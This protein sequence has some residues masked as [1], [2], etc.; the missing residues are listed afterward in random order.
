MFEAAN[1]GVLVLASLEFSGGVAETI[2]S[3]IDFYPETERGQT[4]TL[5]AR[6]MKLVLWQHLLPLKDGSGTLPVREI[7]LNDRVVADLIMAPDK[8]HLLRPAMAAGRPFGMQT[9]HQAL[10]DLKQEGRVPDHE[11]SSFE[12]LTFSHFVY[13]VRKKF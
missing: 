3:I 10:K 5:L 1:R 2:K 7:L 8:L 6:A 11:I 9:M 12:E 4:H 13:P